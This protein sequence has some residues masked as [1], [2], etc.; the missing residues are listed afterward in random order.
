MESETYTVKDQIKD[1]IGIALLVPLCYV[2]YILA[3]VVFA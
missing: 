3:W 1:A 2:C